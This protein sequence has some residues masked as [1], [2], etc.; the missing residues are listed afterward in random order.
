MV[1]ATAPPPLISVTLRRTPDSNCRLLIGRVSV[2][3][4]KPFRSSVASASRRVEV[5]E[6]KPLPTPLAIELRTSTVPP[7][8]FSAATELPLALE[9]LPKMTGPLMVTVPPEMFTVPEAVW[10]ELWVEVLGAMFRPVAPTITVPPEMFRMPEVVPV[11]SPTVLRRSP[12]VT[13]VTSSRPALMLKVAVVEL[14]SLPVRPP[15]LSVL[16]RMSTVWP[17][18]SMSA[19]I[20]APVVEETTPTL[21][22]ARPSPARLR[23]TSEPSVL[24]RKFTRPSERFVAMLRVLMLSVLTPVP[25]RSVWTVLSVGAP[26]I[27]LAATMVLVGARMSCEPAPPPAPPLVLVV[28]PTRRVPPARPA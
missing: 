12:R 11:W 5:T 15:T 8:M 24:S 9:E 25:R 6:A 28:S 3:I 19:N 20:T 14:P 1:L 18:R 21:I 4:V 13:E 22:A 2:P 26:T 17:D 27:R 23:M 16:A 7:V 10:E